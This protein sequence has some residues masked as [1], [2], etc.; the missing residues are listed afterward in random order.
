MFS[1]VSMRYILLISACIIYFSGNAQDTLPQNNQ[2]LWGIIFKMQTKIDGYKAKILKLQADTV[3]CNSTIS[4]SESIL[5][6]AEKEGNIEAKQVAQAAIR[7]AT[8]AKV[9]DI[10]MLKSLRTLKTGFEKALVTAKKEMSENSA[11][12]GK[13]KSVIANFSGSVQIQKVN[14]V[15][16]YYL[17]INTPVSLEA[18]DIISTGA[19]SKVEAQFLEGLGNMNVG[20]STQLK[21]TLDSTGTEIVEL[22]QGKIKLDIGKVEEQIKEQ[23]K[24]LES[25]K[26]PN[27]RSYLEKSIGYLKARINKFKCKFNVRTP[28]ACCCIRGTQLIVTGDSINGTEITVLEGSLEVSGTQDS[29]TT[30][31]NAGFKVIITIDGI[32]SEPIEIDTSTLEK[33]WEK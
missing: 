21:I 16:N 15:K 5:A 9:L 20:E 23:E 12:A 7:K 30:V 17:D 22:K 28:S 26:D 1:F 11:L 24:L 10:E 8:L 14:P 18:G 27:E 2:G 13:T 4:T 19:N 29:G 33:W 6:Q 31:I 25:Y 32:V 3:K